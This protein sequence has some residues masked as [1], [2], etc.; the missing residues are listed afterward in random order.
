MSWS[1]GTIRATILAHLYIAMKDPSLPLL[2]C[3]PFLP[4]QKKYILCGFAEIY[5]W[6]KLLSLVK[7]KIKLWVANEH[8]GMS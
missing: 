4:L 2:A 6:H 1:L 7:I 3:Y 8:E 5:I